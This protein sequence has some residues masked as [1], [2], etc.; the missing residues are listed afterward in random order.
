[1]SYH[2][3]CE[4]CGG[5]GRDKLESERSLSVRPPVT[6]TT[7]A[8]LLGSPSNIIHPG[9][10]SFLTEG[11]LATETQNVEWNFIVARVDNINLVSTA[12]QLRHIIG[13]LVMLCSSHNTY[14]V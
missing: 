14:E 6:L 9:T 7:A 13:R 10:Q 2:Y 8:A 3:C 11:S 4:D 12:A 1:M 5:G